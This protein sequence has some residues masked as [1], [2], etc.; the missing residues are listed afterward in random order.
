MIILIIGPM[1]PRVQ[2]YN[3]KKI[4]KNRKLKTVSFEVKSIIMG[5]A[6]ATVETRP[7]ILN[8]FIESGFVRIRRS[9]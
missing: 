8:K 1:Y 5:K 9:F 7:I 2:W 4:V 3:Y 6:K